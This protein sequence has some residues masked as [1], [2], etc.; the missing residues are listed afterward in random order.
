[1]NN[2]PFIKCEKCGKII[3][4]VFEEF[5]HNDFGKAICK[6]CKHEKWNKKEVKN[7]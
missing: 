3:T 7:G 1:M 2:I 5:Y 6:K 4:D